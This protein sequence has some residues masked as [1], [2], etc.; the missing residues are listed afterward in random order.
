[1]ADLIATNCGKVSGQSIELRD[2]QL[3]SPDPFGIARVTRHE[4]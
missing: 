3:G 2:E 4:I 1:M